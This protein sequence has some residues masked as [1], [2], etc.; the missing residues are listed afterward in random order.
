MIFA[1]GEEGKAVIAEFF[2][3]EFKTFSYIIILYNIY[4]GVIK[5]KRKRGVKTNLLQK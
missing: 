4:I 1:V 2:F 3:I 5:N